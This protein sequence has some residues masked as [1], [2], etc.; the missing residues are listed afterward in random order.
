[1]HVILLTK[2]ICTCKNKAQI[3]GEDGSFT[4]CSLRPTEKYCPT[5]QTY[6]NEKH[7]CA[8]ALLFQPHI[9]QPAG[10]RVQ[11]GWLALLS[12]FS[13]VSPAGLLQFPQQGLKERG[14]RRSRRGQVSL[15][16]CEPEPDSSGLH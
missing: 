2:P 15:L 14:L 16:A 12:S 4:K 7:F 5:Q 3:L 10:R 8:C 6:H 13:M 11:A 9:P 1:M